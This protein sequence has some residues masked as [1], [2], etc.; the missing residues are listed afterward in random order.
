VITGQ[1]SVDE[2]AAAYDKAVEGIVGA[3]GVTRK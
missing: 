2:A 1:Q 3:E